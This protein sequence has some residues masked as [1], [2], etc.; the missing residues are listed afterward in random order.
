MADADSSC[1]AFLC[2][3]VKKGQAHA[4]MVPGTFFSTPWRSQRIYYRFR[5]IFLRMYAI[6]RLIYILQIM[7]IRIC[8]LPAFPEIRILF[9]VFAYSFDVFKLCAGKFRTFRNKSQI[10]YY[11]C[12]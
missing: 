11:T 6:D 9:L 4:Q 10:A 8:Y 7:C 12:G 1:S 3:W 2:Y 5:S